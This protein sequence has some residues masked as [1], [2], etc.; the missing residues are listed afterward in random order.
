MVTGIRSYRGRSLTERRIERRA[1]FIESAL[2]LFGA[3]GYAGTSVPEVCKHA[4]LSSRQFYEEF[5]GR[6]HLLRELYDEVQTGSMTAVS[7]AIDRVLNRPDITVEDLLDAGVG[8]FVDF[9]AASPE[10]TRVSFVEVV[11]VS[12]EFEGHRHARRAEWSA[13]LNTVT[14][15]GREH[16]LS[17]SEAS[18]LVWAGYIGAVNAL[19]VEH[20]V[21]RTITTDE[22]MDA[23]RRL[24]RPGA[25]G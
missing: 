5:S 22:V 17:T 20:S 24:L 18:P 10:R 3:K 21:N 19:I 8:A 12:P 23:M 14:A 13:M 6:E 25:I 2:S 11:G 9:Y 7:T 1:R 16:G 15:L 4:G